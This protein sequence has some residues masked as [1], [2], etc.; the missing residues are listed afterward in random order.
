MCGGQTIDRQQVER[1]RTID[2]Y[3]IVF[4]GVWCNGVLQSG[5]AMA[6]IDGGLIGGAS[7][8]ADEFAMICKSA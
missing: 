1:W 4:T 5:F 2:Q 3:K 6:D 8:I 7:L